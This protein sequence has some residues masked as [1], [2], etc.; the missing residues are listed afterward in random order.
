[1]ELNDR[2]PAVRVTTETKKKLLDIAANEQK[3]RG[4]RVTISDVIREKLESHPD[5]NK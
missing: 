3:R 2:L 4:K 1:M 5:L